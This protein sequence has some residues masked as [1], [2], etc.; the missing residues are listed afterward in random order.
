[1]RFLNS[2]GLLRGKMLDYGCGRGFDA[3]YY[4]M[5]KY[6]PHY[7]PEFPKIKF[8]TITCNYV[9]NVVDAVE[10]GAYNRSSPLTPENGRSIILYDGLRQEGPR[11]LAVG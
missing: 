11:A 9:L 5:D 3:E 4:G 10:M 8:D 1:M 2:L 6:D 7:A